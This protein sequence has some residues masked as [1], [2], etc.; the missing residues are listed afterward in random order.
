MLQSTR[1]SVS[2]LQRLP[3]EEISPVNE[4]ERRHSVR[5]LVECSNV[6]GSTGIPIFS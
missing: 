6:F 5:S 4:H 3:R 2:K 1:L